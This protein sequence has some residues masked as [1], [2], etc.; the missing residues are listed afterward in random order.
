MKPMNF[1]QPM[2]R[3][4]EWAEAK[5][6][7]LSDLPQVRADAL[8]VL[9]RHDL[10]HRIGEEREKYIWYQTG[11]EGNGNIDI[12]WQERAEQMEARLMWLTRR[13]D[14][15]KWDDL[16]PLSDLRPEGEKYV[17]GRELLW[18]IDER[19][20]KESTIHLANG[21]T[22]AAAPTPKDALRGSDHL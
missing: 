7:L 20:E 2:T 4:R 15:C 19:L 9:D 13:L 10:L 17:I 21:S 1:F 8:H 16:G 3:L 11:S 5:V 22:I 12:S 14:G 18:G 6:T